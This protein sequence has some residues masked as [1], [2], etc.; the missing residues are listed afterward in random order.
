MS[1]FSEKL[2]YYIKKSRLTLLH[3]SAVSGLDVSYISKIK[4]GERLPRKKDLLVP[5]VNGLRLS[6]SEKKD[7]WDAYKISFIGEKQ[8]TQYQAV[9]KFFSS[10][11][12]TDG[13]S[14]VCH[15]QHKI[16]SSSAHYGKTNVNHIV[17][18]VLE[19]ECSHRNGHIQIVAQPDYQFLMEVL[20]SVSFCFP[21][22]EITQIICLQSGAETDKLAYNVESFQSMY[23][24]LSCSD[25]YH[26]KYYYDDI[27]SH[28]NQMNVMPFFILT[29]D[30]IVSLSADYTL[31]DVSSNSERQKLYTSIFEQM[32]SCTDDLIFHEYNSNLT[33]CS[34]EPAKDTVSKKPF[35]AEL[36]TAPFLLP[37]YSDRALKEMVRTDIPNS[38]FIMDYIL[39]YAKKMRD[40]IQNS[41]NYLSLFT[42]RGTSDFLQ[43]GYL[44]GFSEKFFYPLKKEDTIS[45][46]KKFCSKQVLI[47]HTP[48]LLKPDCLTLSNSFRIFSDSRS[49]TLLFHTEKPFTL[50]EQSLIISIKDFFKYII[51]S[52]EV[53]SPSDTFKFMHRQILALEKQ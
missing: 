43:T 11:S 22:L 30:Y 39:S 9:K 52:D 42:E 37:Y 48:L 1:L 8:F 13:E 50:T 5:V 18:T 38:T 51:D 31:A 24:L 20:C 28:I 35:F 6:P 47:Q 45:A 40:T 7:L 16:L 25:S 2:S 53:Y 3:L 41:S 34:L 44:S 32:F 15:F 49:S 46:L 33:A 23:P 17:K 19:S 27:P 10:I 12:G 14:V 26:V 36:S 29:T 21:Q 4:K